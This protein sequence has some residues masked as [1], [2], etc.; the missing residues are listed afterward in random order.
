MK[1]FIWVLAASLFFAA[2]NN[3]PAAKK[4]TAKADTTV[5]TATTDT[6]SVPMTGNDRD[7]HGCIGSAGYTWSVVKND[8]IRIFEAG[9]RLN[10]AEAVTDKT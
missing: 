7:E 6:V 9:K 1:R 5:K 10:A 3:K 4:E 8:C 2:C